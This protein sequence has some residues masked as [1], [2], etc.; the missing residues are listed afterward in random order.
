MR[1]GCTFAIQPVSR[2]SNA[3]FLERDRKQTMTTRAQRRP[4]GLSVMTTLTVV[5]AIALAILSAT[6][7]LTFSRQELVAHQRFQTFKGAFGLQTALWQVRG[8][9]SDGSILVSR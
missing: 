6:L 9:L 1:L 2:R 7:L 4:D 3:A 5:M 8:L